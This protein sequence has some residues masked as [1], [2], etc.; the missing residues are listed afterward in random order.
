MAPLIHKK[1]TEELH[2]PLG[3]S[4]T[5][6]CL[7]FDPKPKIPSLDGWEAPSRGNLGNQHEFSIPSHL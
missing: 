1:I 2:G 7:V 6:G 4:L 3:I 5:W